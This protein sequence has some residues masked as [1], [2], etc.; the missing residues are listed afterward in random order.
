MR[1][2]LEVAEDMAPGTYCRAANGPSLAP[3]E[4]DTGDVCEP[5]SQTPKGTHCLNGLQCLEQHGSCIC[6]CDGCRPTRTK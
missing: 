6:L 1:R 3:W 5:R 4:L 2:T